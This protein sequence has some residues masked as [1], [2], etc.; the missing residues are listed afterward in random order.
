MSIAALGP[1][2]MNTN[3][4]SGYANQKKDTLGRDEFLTMLVAQLQ[5]Q[6]PLNPLDGTDFTAQLAQFSSLE[7]LFGMNESLTG[8]HETLGA[9]QES[10]L[11]DLIGK[12]VKAEDNSI[13]VEHDGI[14]S[15]S[16]TLE[17]R[18]DVTIT[19]YDSNGQEVRKLYPGWQDAGD[20]DVEWDG[21]DKSGKMSEN[22]AYTFE[23]SAKDDA[24]HYVTVNTYVSGEVTGVTYEYGLPYLMIGDKLVSTDHSIV[25]VTSA[26][27]EE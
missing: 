24:G 21:R 25:E 10:D 6:D 7:Q 8:I 15:G 11:F 4:M 17:D 19:I 1:T 23:I 20:Y 16:Y 2:Y 9:Q 13:H 3:E 22:G 18:A 14:V 27:V 26:K 5:H 12:R